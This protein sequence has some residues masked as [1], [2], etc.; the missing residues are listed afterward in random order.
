MKAYLKKNR[1][2]P[3]LIICS[4]AERTRETYTRIS[5]AFPRKTEVKFEH[6]L[7]DANSQTLLKRLRRIDRKI[8]SVMMI[9]HNT[10]LEHFALALTSGTE[11]KPLARMRQKFPTLALASIEIPKGT[12]AAAS[13]GC[14][15]LTDFIVPR[16]LKGGKV[17]K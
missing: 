15:R 14:A 11:T 9:G 2:K 1:I 8:S 12:W 5:A 4:P 6:T 7:Y 16:D 10:A 17:K 3:D 13:P